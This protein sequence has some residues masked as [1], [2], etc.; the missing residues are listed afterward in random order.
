[1]IERNE[2]R[3]QNARSTRWKVTQQLD[4]SREGSYASVSLFPLLDVVEVVVV[5]LHFAEL[6]VLRAETRPI[7]LANSFK[8]Y[9][10]NSGSA[11]AALSTWSTADSANTTDIM[12]NLLFQFLPFRSL[13]CT[14]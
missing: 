9:S 8:Q 11:A 2:S 6:A 1:V 4:Q 12:V 3:Q 13:Y 5:F 7:R 10:L 14:S